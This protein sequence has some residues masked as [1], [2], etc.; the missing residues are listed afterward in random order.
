MYL[1]PFQLCFYNFVLIIYFVIYEFA[2]PFPNVCASLCVKAKNFILYPIWDA[3]SNLL[4]FTK[5]FH[6]CATQMLAKSAV[7]YHDF[8][9]LSWWRKMRYKSR[10]IIYD[11]IFSL[12]FCTL[13]QNVSV[14]AY[15]VS[16]SLSK[17]YSAVWWNYSDIRMVCY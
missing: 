15:V 16:A 10:I 2:F 6:I 9:F 13:A 5:P 17:S 11:V 1:V 4:F 3:L 8:L 14:L 12:L 7:R